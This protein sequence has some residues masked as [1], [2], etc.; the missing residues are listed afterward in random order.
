[1]NKFGVREYEI[2]NISTAITINIGI[3]YYSFQMNL[4]Y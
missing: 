3:C 1:M 4:S 2:R